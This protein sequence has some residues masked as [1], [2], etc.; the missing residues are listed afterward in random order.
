MRARLDIGTGN[1]TFGTEFSVEDSKEIFANFGLAIH[2]SNVLEASILHALF[3]YK[4]APMR[5]QFGSIEE[6]DAAYDNFYETGFAKTFG[7]LIK[8]VCATNF[9]TDDEVET[10]KACKTIRDNLVH[11]FM[12]ENAES[13]YTRAGRE[14]MIAQCEGSVAIFEA[15]H[16]LIEAACERQLDVLGVDKARWRAKIEEGMDRLIKDGLN[17]R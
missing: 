16:D 14:Q 4:I 3:M 5:H 9:L 17:D 15:A 8:E 6:W 11:R 7:N 12:R 1:L 2:V 10:L 13:I